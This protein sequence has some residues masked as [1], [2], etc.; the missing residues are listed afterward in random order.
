MTPEYKMLGCF[1]IVCAVI[2]L[3]IIGMW[4]LHEMTSGS[5]D[6]TPNGGLLEV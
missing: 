5:T 4:I 6:S 2:I 3:L 1:L